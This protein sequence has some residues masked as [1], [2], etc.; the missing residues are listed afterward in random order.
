MSPFSTCDGVPYRI[1]PIRP[2]DAQRERDF[3]E[4]LSPR[5]RYQRFM[6]H[7][8]EPGEAFVRRLVNVDRHRTMALVATI[9]EADAERII[10]V[11]RYAA[12]D[13]RSCEFA[14]TVA[15]EWQCRGIATTLVPKLF[16]HAARQGFELIYGLVLADN[17]RM[18]DLAQNLRLTVDA[19][20]PGETTVRAWRRL[21][22]WRASAPPCQPSRDR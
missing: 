2:D 4:G 18:I 15:D 21:R 19:R 22:G 5:S 17:Q 9:G 8:R 12:D 11:A 6:H 20:A 3:I 16:E 1:R 13:D 10:A 14:V 7:F